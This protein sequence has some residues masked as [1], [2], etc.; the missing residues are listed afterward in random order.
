ME[1]NYLY[2]QGMPVVEANQYNGDPDL[3]ILRECMAEE[4]GSVVGYLECAEIIRDYRIEKVFRGAAND[5][6]SHF[7][8]LLQLLTGLDQGQAAEMKKQELA[9]L[10]AASDG[11]CPYHSDKASF[12]SHKGDYKK[13]YSP[14]EL[15]WDMLRN[16]IKDELY[17]MNA[18]QRQIQT[19]TNPM[20]QSVLIRLMNQEKEHFVAFTKLFYEVYGLHREGMVLTD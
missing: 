6:L 15:L 8:G 11:I 17:S 1:Y 7:A 9:I 2:P 18:Y 5:E 10:T 13:E 16:A 12:K 20:V 3:I 19:V 4:M 14:N